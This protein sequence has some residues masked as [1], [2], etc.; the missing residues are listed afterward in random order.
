SRNITLAVGAEPPGGSAGSAQSPG[1][2]AAS[3]LNAI[4]KSVMRTTSSMSA[5]LPTAQDLLDTGE[6]LWSGMQ[7][8]T[9]DYVRDLDT[10]PAFD[11]AALASLSCLAGG[12][13][14]PVCDVSV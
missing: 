2:G 14:N 9:N 13:L 10:N 5:L 4:T 6:A 7:S 8:W 1:S 11:A 3:W 12:P